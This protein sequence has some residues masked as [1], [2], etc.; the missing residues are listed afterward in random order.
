MLMN[1]IHLKYSQYTDNDLHSY[2]QILTNQFIITCSNLMYWYESL[3]ESYISPKISLYERNIQPH[4]HISWG[5]HVALYLANHVVLCSQLMKQSCIPISHVLW[6][7]FSA[8][9]QSYISPK[10]SFYKI[11]IQP[12]VHISWAKHEALYLANH[13]VTMFTVHETIMLP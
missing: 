7:M 9:N 4:V 12:H 6:R 13:V 11:N 10:K 1:F 5:K 3:Y 2:V 8:L